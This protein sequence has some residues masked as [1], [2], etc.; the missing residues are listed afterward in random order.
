MGTTAWRPTRMHPGHVRGRQVKT[1]PQA[2]TAPMGS[3]FPWGYAPQARAEDPDSG[4]ESP[5]RPGMIFDP[6]LPY[7]DKG[8][9]RACLG[10]L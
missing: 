1:A 7:H 3:L 9:S 6:S 5:L 4:A 8:Q 2:G 10:S